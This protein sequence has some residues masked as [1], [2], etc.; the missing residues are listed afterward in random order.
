MGLLGQTKDFV[1][2]GNYKGVEPSRR[3]DDPTPEFQGSWYCHT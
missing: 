2:Y 1:Q 3:L